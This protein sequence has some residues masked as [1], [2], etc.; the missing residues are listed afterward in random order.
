MTQTWK[1]QFTLKNGK[2]KQYSNP[3]VLKGE[4]A[5]IW[6][7]ERRHGG[8]GGGR[9][10]RSPRRQ[11]SCLWG[12][13]QDLQRKHS[14]STSWAGLQSTLFAK[15]SRT[16]APPSSAFHF[17]A[18]GKACGQT[19]SD[20]SGSFKKY[21][22]KSS[23]PAQIEYDSEGQTIFHFWAKALPCSRPDSGGFVILKQNHPVFFFSFSSQLS[24]H[25]D[26]K[27]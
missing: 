17:H 16:G 23:G 6:R 12:E 21:N 19:P 1:E 9:S 3:N 22:A 18:A 27:N 4:Q 26:H 25:I 14:V 15:G 2:N 11:Q 8:G 7:G 13:Q 10:S 5:G 20:R 24:S